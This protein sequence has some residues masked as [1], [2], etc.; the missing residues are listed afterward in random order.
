MQDWEQGHYLQP[1]NISSALDPV[2]ITFISS[3]D[4]ISK[5]RGM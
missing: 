5:K 1:K 2:K 4:L 3:F